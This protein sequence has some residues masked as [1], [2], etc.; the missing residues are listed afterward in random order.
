M[1]TDCL[2]PLQQDFGYYLRSVIILVEDSTNLDDPV[3]LESQ[4]NGILR[5]ILSS[6]LTRL[7]VGMPELLDM[8]VHSTHHHMLWD[9]AS[10]SIRYQHAVNS[11]EL[12]LLA[13]Q[14]LPIYTLC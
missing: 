1:V 12:G 4:R 10:M 9:N 7:F 14:P 8:M 3:F 2:E 6:S 5:V 11:L 13:I